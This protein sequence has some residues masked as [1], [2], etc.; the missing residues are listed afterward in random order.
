VAAVHRPGGALWLGSGALAG[1]T[2]TDRLLALARKLGE[3]GE[4]GLILDWRWAKPPDL[5]EW[6]IWRSVV[7]L[8]IDQP[9]PMPAKHERIHYGWSEHAGSSYQS[10]WFLHGA[11]SLHPL[12]DEACMERL[13]FDNLPV[14]ELKSY[15]G[16]VA[17]VVNDLALSYGEEL[18]AA[19]QQA[20][21]VRLV[22]ETQDQGRPAEV[23]ERLWGGVE[24]HL[25]LHRL[26]LPN[27][28]IAAAP[29]QTLA[30]G[31][32]PAAAV[33][34][35][36]TLLRKAPVGAGRPRPFVF[37]A[38]KPACTPP[39][40]R[41]LSREERL[42]G[43]FKM[44]IALGELF[45]HLEFV[46]GDWRQVI[47]RWA[48]R[49][50][51]AAAPTD[52]AL[53]VIELAATLNDSHVWVTAPDDTRLLP[54][55]YGGYTAPLT[56]RDVEGR[57][58]LVQLH[59]D[60]AAA[61]GA[62][63]GMDVSA[64]DGRP[65]EALVSERSALIS[66]STPQS[67]RSRA[68]KLA[69]VGAKDSLAS[70]TVDDGTGARTV[71][72]ARDLAAGAPAGEPQRSQAAIRKVEEFGYIDLDRVDSEE[73][74]VRTFKEF[75]AAPGLIFDMRGYPRLWAQFVVVSRLIKA[76]VTGCIYLCPQRSGT[77][78]ATQRIG[79]HAGR[80]EQ[81]RRENYVVEPDPDIHYGG[82]VV[83]LI[84][85]AAISSAEDFCIY[86]KNARRA[87]FVGTATTGTNGNVT[88]VQL[89][90]GIVIS[91][92]GMRVTHADGARFQNIGI[93]PDVEARPTLAGLRAGRDEVL[94][95]GVETLRQL[96][97]AG[98]LLLEG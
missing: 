37:T 41:V 11:D 82:P 23:P 49:F 79:P 7:A 45:P 10:S 53:A 14:A 96:V 52:H 87:A 78:Y 91:F 56:L 9:L 63:V 80:I 1:A 76:P 39:A 94:E 40:A 35:A 75:S 3:A 44:W 46:A 74:I 60:R 81:W 5:G 54:A 12:R 51:R 30:A 32:D 77:L 88:Q 48:P 16:P 95:A 4:G 28:W 67:L 69:L 13:A 83:V 15:A 2:R 43:L 61:A 72:L 64:I 31:A 66:A 27:G 89:P 24:A 68:L 62:K 50:E 6:L 22:V 17:I 90:G 59:G 42:A 36:E 19:L 97:R 38:P 71:T 65:I 20:G 8:L 26:A 57:A 73:E 21:R 25:R 58:A 55:H 34:A 47:Q 84:D 86:M 85:E 93:L 92:T 18:L 70:L 98:R 29:D 33:A